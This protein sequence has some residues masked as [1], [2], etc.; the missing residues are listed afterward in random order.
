MRYFER[1][2]DEFRGI[3]EARVK[4]VDRKQDIGTL[5][6]NVREAM[7]GAANQ[8]MIREAGTKRRKLVPR[9]NDECREAIKKQN[10]AFK[11]L[12]KK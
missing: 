11:E 2:S 5:N 7:I 12:E 6:G 9:W 4:N 8:T 1:L 10:K 3:S